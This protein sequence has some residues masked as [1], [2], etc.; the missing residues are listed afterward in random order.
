MLPT[1]KQGRFIKGQ[2]AWNKG[3]KIP[4]ISG[5]NSPHW[6]GGKKTSKCFICKTPYQHFPS[7]KSKYCSM[8]CVGKSKFKGG[9]LTPSG[10]KVIP[11]KNHPF[12][13]KYKNSIFEHRLVMERHLGRYLKPKETVHHINGIK[14]DNRIE[15]LQLVSDVPHYGKIDCPFCHNNFLIK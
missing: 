9:Y 5:E 3:K 7:Q 8:D 13:S 4:Q 15:N 14:D 10:Y 1:T 11:V 6:K 2:K 12:A